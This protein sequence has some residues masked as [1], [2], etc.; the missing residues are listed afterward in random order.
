MNP[1]DIMF[2]KYLLAVCKTALI[3][4]ETVRNVIDSGTHSQINN[5]I[6]D[7]MAQ[8]G[9]DRALATESATSVKSTE[10]QRA[11]HIV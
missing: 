7:F 3:H 11:R 10:W 1:N 5:S 6:I 4:N 2:A 9:V 8:E